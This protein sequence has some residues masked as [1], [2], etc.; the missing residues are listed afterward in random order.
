M[1]VFISAVVQRMV[2]SDQSG[3]MFTV[4]PATNNANEVVIEAVY[5]LG[6]M[7]VGGQVNPDLYIVDKKTRDIKKTELKTKEMGMFRTEEGKNEK[8]PIP[9]ELQKRQ[10]IPDSHVKE[11]TRLGLK[12]E[13]HYKK[14]QDIEWAIEK[15]QIFIVQARAVTTFKE[16]KSEDVKQVCEENAKILVKQAKNA[17]VVV[18]RQIVQKV[19]LFPALVAV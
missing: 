18:A 12:I 16:Q 7:I 4:N 8:R 13:E 1:K 19:H 17:Q 14:P 9:K 10:V 6:E 11:L 3:I 5:G 15:D 2:N